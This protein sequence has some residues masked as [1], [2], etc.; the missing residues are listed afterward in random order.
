MDAQAVGRILSRVMGRTSDP[1]II[2]DLIRYASEEDQE[3]SDR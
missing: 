3:N 2:K 1:E